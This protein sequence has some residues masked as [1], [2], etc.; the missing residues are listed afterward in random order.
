MIDRAKVSSK[1]YGI[2]KAYSANS[3]SGPVLTHNQD[4]ICIVTNLTKTNVKQRQISFFGIYDGND[5]VAKADYMRDN[6]HVC[7]V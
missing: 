3:H 7:L 1:S 2:V 6:F 5:G 4:R